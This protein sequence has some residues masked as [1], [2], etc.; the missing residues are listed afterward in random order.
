MLFAVDFPTNNQYR[1]RDMNKPNYHLQLIKFNV[2]QL[3]NEKEKVFPAI[4]KREK[5]V[6][7]IR[8]GKL[9]VHSVAY[10]LL[11]YI[12]L[13]LITECNNNRKSLV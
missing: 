6:I 2:T 4:G 10:T 13:E 8:V 9:I 12:L 1:G 11:T 3:I 7:N 5:E